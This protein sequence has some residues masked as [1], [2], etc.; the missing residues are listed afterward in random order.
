ME[1]MQII[2]HIG[3]DAKILNTNGVDW[4]KFTVACYS[5]FKKDDGTA[6]ETTNWYNCTTKQTKIAPYLK[7]GTKVFVQGKLNTSIYKDSNNENKISRD[8]RAEKLELLS[9]KETETENEEN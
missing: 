1:Q 9:K 3:Q 7:K 4:L 2:G 5:S 8:L 6:V